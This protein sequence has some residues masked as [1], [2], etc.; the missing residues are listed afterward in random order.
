MTF[1]T[2]LPFRLATVSVATLALAA[3]GPD[4][5][6]NLDQLA[7]SS[8]LQPYNFSLAD[9]A[10]PFDDDGLP[11]AYPM[12]DD[13]PESYAPAPSWNY[14]QNSYYDAPQRQYASSYGYGD[15]GYDGDGYGQYDADYG[16][17]YYEEA[18]SS[19]GDQ[20][21]YDRSAGTDQY[22]W[23]A[24]AAM[25]GRVL[26]D[27]PPDYAYRYND[28]Q[29]WAWR[30]NDGYYRHAEP[31]RGGY[32]YYYYEPRSARPFLV[33]DPIYSY[34]Y[35]ENRLI[36]VYDRDGRVLRRDRMRER[37]RAGDA[38][39]D[40][41]TRLYRAASSGDRFGVS[42]PLW[43]RRS[44]SIMAE[45]RRWDRAR[46]ERRAWREWD[47][48]HERAAD[49]RWKQERRAR[50][51]ANRQFVRW[52]RDDYRSA[53]PVLYRDASQ[54]RFERASLFRVAD[55]DARQERRRELRRLA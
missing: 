35:R 3:C 48:R 31:V 47:R 20:P 2:K 30:T 39:F 51:D 23:L 41:G 43:Q 49:R 52:Q 24:L 16:D 25:V 37:Y 21:Y 10:Y 45:Q 55:G 26:G 32:R 14:G 7:L 50:R 28:V 46:A 15:D 18:Y 40:R 38:Y 54:P 5:A 53:A 6:P 34:G 11:E 22:S 42:A 36:A 17:D 8:S 29:P 19:H 1:L 33:R 4:D 13:Y 9:D 12:Q 44:G 27:S